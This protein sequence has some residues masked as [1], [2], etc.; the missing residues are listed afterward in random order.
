VALGS[1]RGNPGALYEATRGHDFDIESWDWIAAAAPDPDAAPTEQIDGWAWAWLFYSKWAG[2]VGRRPAYGYHVRRAGIGPLL[3]AVEIRIAELAEDW[4]WPSV[5]ELEH[6]DTDR[7]ETTYALLEAADFVGRPPDPEHGLINDDQ[8]ALSERARAWR[9]AIRLELEARGQLPRSY[10]ELS[11]YD[12]AQRILLS[13]TQLGVDEFGRLIPRSRMTKIVDEWCEFFRAG[14]SPI[15]YLDVISRAPKR[16]VASLLTQTQLRG[17]AIKWGDYDD[18][19]A[20]GGMPE[21]WTADLGGATALTDLTPLQEARSLR[22]L[23][24]TDTRRA[25]DYSPLDRLVDLEEF[26][27]QS[28]FTSP[29]LKIPNIAFLRGM[30]GLRYLVIDGQVLDGDY[31]ALLDRADV[32]ELWLYRQR[33]MEPSY[34]ELARRIPGMQVR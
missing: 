7:L 34:E 32:E 5:H 23:R 11:E 28:G 2:T 18:I 26:V 14:P 13:P 9:L 30:T 27:L 4:T 15:R 12:G 24:L 21:L 20:L 31:S 10:T 16:L 17:L 3:H 8:S 1:F 6:L 19:S 22:V 25:T 29:R 33:S